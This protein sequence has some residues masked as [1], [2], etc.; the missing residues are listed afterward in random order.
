MQDEVVVEIQYFKGCPNSVEMI[1]RVKDAIQE[2]DSKI[3][4][5]ETLVEDNLT[6]QKV[7]FRGSPTLLIDGQDFE[8]L[9]ESKNPNLS[10]RFYHNGLP[11]IEEIKNKIQTKISKDHI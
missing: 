11:T 6:A 8:N 9:E 10:C 4:Y 2:F 1:E 5:F 3:N 7:S